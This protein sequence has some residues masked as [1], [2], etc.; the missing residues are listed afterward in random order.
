VSVLAIAIRIMTST[1][2]GMLLAAIGLS[3][4]LI[5]LSLWLLRG[6]NGPDRSSSMPARFFLIALRV[7]IG[8]HCFI[9]GMEKLSTPNWSSE[10][11]LRES[12]GPLSEHY[13]AVAGDRLVDKLTVGADGAFPA[14]LDSEWRDYVNTFADY[15]ELDAD[16]RTRAD[17]ILEQRKADTLIYLTTKSETVTKL[18]PYPPELNLDMTMKQRLAEHQRLLDAVLAEEGRFPS[19]DKEVHARWKSAKADL[20]K[21]RGMFKKGID[22]EMDKLK[23]INPAL[24]DTLKK[25]IDAL[26]AKRAKATDAKE[27]KKL[28]GDLKEATTAL[29][30][31]LTDVLTSEQKLK[32]RMPE[33]PAR[34]Y[35]S[36]RMLEWSD[37]GVKWGLIVLGAALML[38]IFGRLSCAATGL[39]VLSFYLAMPPLPG[40]PESPRLEGHYFLVNKTLIEIIALFALAFIPTSRWAGVDGL[41]SLCCCSKEK[42][43]TAP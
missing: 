9:E 2:S 16:Q 25:K 10:A 36:W 4:I 3:L 13:R 24:K 31:P 39:L 22:A 34:P 17:G 1:F 37:F 8:W 6:T 33:P 20:A 21:W 5:T 32:D 27:T 26:T 41:L 14:E 7:A 29:W 40:W 18:A 19:D 38:G 43:S 30:E 35:T 28:D 15:Y 12:M 42:T 11:Y 23:T